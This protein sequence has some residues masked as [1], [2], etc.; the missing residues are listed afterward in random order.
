MGVCARAKEDF[1]ESS[2][3]VSMKNLSSPSLFAMGERVNPIEFKDSFLE[4][5]GGTKEDSI[6]VFGTRMEVS[7]IFIFKL[8]MRK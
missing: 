5:F 3:G 1:L 7:Q 2:I 8:K 4:A 6:E